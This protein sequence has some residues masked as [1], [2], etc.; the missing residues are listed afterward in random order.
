MANRA[1]VIHFEKAAKQLPL[2]AHWTAQAQ[3][4]HQ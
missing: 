3:S 1:I 2:A 4:A